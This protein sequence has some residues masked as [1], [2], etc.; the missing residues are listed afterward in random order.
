MTQLQGKKILLAI[1]GSIAAYK[2]PELVR[3]F[4]KLGAEVKV[5]MT[6]SA[7]DFVSPLALS[8]VSKNP[9]LNS[10]HESS[11]WNN[12]VALGRW[13]DVMLIAPCS[14]NTLAKLAN[15]LCDN[16]LCAVYL[17]ATCPVF[18]APAMDEDM[19]AH[20]ATKKNVEMIRSFG[21]KIIP[22]G[23]GEL[24]SGLFGAGRLAE[25]EYLVA[26]LEQ[27]FEGD[28]SSELK[29]QKVLITAGPTY[30]K[31][32]PVRFIGN[33]STGKMGIALADEL[34]AKGAAVKLV[35][36]PSVLRPIHPSINTVLV[37]SAA[38]MLKAAEQDFEAYDIAIFAA[39]V[40]DYRP[41]KM[42]AEKIKKA[43]KS[44]EIKLQKTDDILKTL[45]ARKSPKQIV[46]GFALETQNEE[47]N[48]RKKLREKGAD[49]IVLNSLKVAGAGFGHD[50][51]QV[52]IFSADGTE[53]KHPLQSKSETA[54]TIVQAII[55]FRNAGINA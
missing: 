52:T 8:T 40:A 47:A 15:G 50:T 39:A 54:R 19:W 3:Q 31:L 16:L 36:G 35:L 20:P 23:H 49:I 42:A 27:F 30:E 7:A 11:S 17:S 1:S 53:V 46:V 5:L 32:D 41:I 45:A 48:A 44:L 10:V 28:S 6:P 51:N 38:E 2:M 22:V 25:L 55:S 12:H 26:A 43:G 13:A 34:A 4:I 18:V 14:A 24:A 29:G 9:V 21:N 37:A 33:H